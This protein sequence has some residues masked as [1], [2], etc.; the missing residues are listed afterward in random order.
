MPRSSPMTRTAT[1]SV[2]KTRN[3]R[4]H[5]IGDSHRRMAV[6]GPAVVATLSRSTPA[7]TIQAGVVE[8]LVLGASLTGGWRSGFEQASWP[9]RGRLRRKAGELYRR[10]TRL[11]M[12][13][14]T[15]WADHRSPLFKARL[16]RERP[17][18]FLTGGHGDFRREAGARQ[19]PVRDNAR[20]IFQQ[21]AFCRDLDT[22]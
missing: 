13:Q 9:Q 2:S 7:C 22:R 17:P 18:G 1:S 4:L 11:S 15:T 12:T 5:H 19:T 6:V 10:V 8:T 16:I 14:R 3:D 21:P 20:L